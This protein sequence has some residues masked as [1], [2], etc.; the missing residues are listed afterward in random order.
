[1]R[2]RILLIVLFLFIRNAYSQ[3]FN[4]G[5]RLGV[6]GS[7]VNGDR[8]T[9]FD[10]VGLI[11][12]AF[13][14]RKFS[15]KVSVQMEIVFI[16]KGSRK[17]TDDN[18]SF[19]RM[20]VHYMEVPLL[21]RFHTSKKFALSAGPSFGTLIFAEEDDEFGVYKNAPPFRKFEFAGNA[22]LLYN[23]NDHWAFDGRYSHSITTIRPYQA[24][25]PDFFDKGQYN[26][27]IEFSLL[28]SF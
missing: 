3:K 26:V 6:A 17:P 13:V 12:G 9:G 21:F 19:Y 5:F 23:L 11:G 28:Y 27:L 1:M 8:L 2:G 15:E 18:N 25:N 14:N 4:A 20:R 7:Q 22:G 10:K 16:Q 24:Y